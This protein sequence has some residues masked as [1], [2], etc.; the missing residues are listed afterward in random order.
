MGFAEHADSAVVPRPSGQRNRVDIQLAKMP[1]DERVHAVR[2]LESDRS[3]AHVADLFTA[4]GYPVKW[5]S[6]R[7]WRLTNGVQS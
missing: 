4:E 6:V 1:A 2:L 5:G 3:S 7:N